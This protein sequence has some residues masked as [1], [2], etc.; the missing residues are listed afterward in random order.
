[1]QHGPVPEPSET[2][3]ASD[4][5]TMIIRRAAELFESDGYHGTN[6]SQI[7]LAAGIRKPTL[8]HY[9]AGKEAI[10][11]GIHREAM[12]RLFEA[13]ARR[14]DNLSATAGLRGIVSDVLDLMNTLKGSFRV[15][16]EH[17]RDLSPENRVT[18]GKERDR[19]R[20]LIEDVLRRGIEN[21]EFRPV[22]PRLVTLALA[23]MCNWAY[24]WY[25]PEGNSARSR[26]PMSSPSWS[27]KASPAAQRFRSRPGRSYGPRPPGRSGGSGDN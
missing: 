15:V 9:F 17:Y 26:S 3:P 27:S 2:G 10:L 18:I 23:G 14:P 11:F 21:G 24:Q 6:M 12:L 5:R 4:K 16:S 7:A 19:Y 8:Y 25:R 1:M 13:H 22:D 20:Q